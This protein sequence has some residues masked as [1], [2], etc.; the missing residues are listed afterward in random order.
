MIVDYDRNPALTTDQKLQSLIESLLR[1]RDE[2]Q[3]SLADIEKR[4]SKLEQESE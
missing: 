4:L 2:L 3:D 1:M